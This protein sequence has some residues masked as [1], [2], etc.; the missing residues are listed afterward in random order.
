MAKIEPDAELSRDTI[1]QC[2]RDPHL[3]REGREGALHVQLSSDEGAQRRPSDAIRLV[4]ADLRGWRASEG[5]GRLE[6][7]PDAKAGGA[8]LSDPARLHEAW[9]HSARSFLRN[10][11]DG[12]SGEASRS[13]LDRD[14]T[15]I[16]LREG[17]S[18]AHR[19]DTSARRKRNE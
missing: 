7:P 10:R 19:L 12:R 8:S 1:H 3:V 13:A 4:A 14:R 15:G 6:G 11:Y 5:R 16:V 9:R 17:R 18:R 2:S